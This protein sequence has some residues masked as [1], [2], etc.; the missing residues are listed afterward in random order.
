MLSFLEPRENIAQLSCP[1]L[2]SALATSIQISSCHSFTIPHL[3]F[4][5]ILSGDVSW[6]GIRVTLRPTHATFYLD[7]TSAV[8]GHQITYEGA[9]ATPSH[10]FRLF[11]TRDDGHSRYDH[12]T[13]R[14]FSFP[15]RPGLRCRALGHLAPSLIPSLKVLAKS[16]LG[17]DIVARATATLSWRSTTSI[18]RS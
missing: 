17:R 6:N 7:R 11:V 14:H 3:R 10:P 9:H 15:T 18:C 5:I 12:V 16:S 2:Q 1:I 13:S 8:F 4:A